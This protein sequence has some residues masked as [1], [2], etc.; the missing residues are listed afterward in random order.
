MTAV[1]TN[2]RVLKPSRKPPQVGDVFAMQVPGGRY[3]FGRVVSVSA[4]WT[5]AEGAGPAILIYIYNVTGSAKGDPPLDDLR[6]NRLLISPAMT[7]RLPWSRGYFQTVVNRPLQPDDLL[8]RHVFRSASRGTY[9]DEA[10][11]EVTDPVEP[12]GDFA[13]HSFR[14][15]DDQISDALGIPRVPA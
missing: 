6:T 3:L 14:T 4:R 11:R 9:Y 15:L 13:L 7:N 12:I 1:Q 10:G 5:I 2:L 8:A